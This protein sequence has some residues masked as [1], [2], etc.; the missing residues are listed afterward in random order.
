MWYFCTKDLTGCT[1]APAIVSCYFLVQR[2]C[3]GLMYQSIPEPPIPPPPGQTPGHLTFLKN[4][5]QIP[6][7]VASLDGQMPHPLELQRGSN[8]PPSR[9][10]KAT[11][12]NFFSC[13][14]PFIQMYV[15]WQSQP[16]RLN[17]SQVFLFLMRIKFN[18]YKRC[19]SSLVIFYAFYMSQW[20]TSFL[21][22]FYLQ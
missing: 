6:R 14:K 5:G 19:M 8:P 3:W 21:I 1:A 15:F 22:F 13:V 20:L 4:F 18:E 11:V 17:L 16:Q 12:L 7:Y 2:M 9:H 10:V